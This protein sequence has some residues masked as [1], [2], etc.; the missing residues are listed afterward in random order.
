MRSIAIILVVAALVCYPISFGLAGVNDD[1]PKRSSVK[2]PLGDLLDRPRLKD[3]KLRL[4]FVESG[5]IIHH[6]RTLESPADLK[7]FRN[8]LEKAKVLDN[9]TNYD[10]DP[11]SAL[12]LRYADG[13]PTSIG[14]YS[15]CRYISVGDGAGRVYYEISETKLRK[16]CRP[17]LAP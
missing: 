1:T 16:L 2:G 9:P 7:T 8:I 3:V 14:L 12:T 10:T 15:P 13:E 4:A 5:K 6:E 17:D 11:D